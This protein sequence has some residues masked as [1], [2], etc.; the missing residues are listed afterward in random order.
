MK[1]TELNIYDLMKDWFNFCFENPDKINSNHSAMYFF[2]IEHCNRMGW[3]KKFGLPMQMTMDAIGI[4]NYK[5]FSRT[6]KDLI[7]W[8][9]IIL[10]QKSSNQYSANV[11]GLVKTTKASTNALSKASLKHSQKQV[12]GIVGIDIPI[13]NTPI[14]NLQERDI[15]NI[16]LNG[17]EWKKD[18]QV[19]LD[20]LR[21]AYKEILKDEDWIEKQQGYYPKI[22]IQKTLLKSCENFWATEGGWKNKKNARIKEINWKLTFANA[23]SQKIN[24]VYGNTEI[25][26]GNSKTTSGNYQGKQN[27]DR[28]STRNNRSSIEALSDLAEAIIQN[29]NA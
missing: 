28:T 22:D 26:N 7:S 18:Y 8:G 5:T 25:P 2:M 10:Y 13:T 15:N 1:G 14:T 11:I 20:G 9:F 16:S 21:Q 24:H 23:L 4:K 12:H 6:F 27:T 29:A 3:K 19:Y 17:G